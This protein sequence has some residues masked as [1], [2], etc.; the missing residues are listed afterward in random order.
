MDGMPIK[1]L[2]VGGASRGAL[3]FQSYVWIT[4]IG[5]RD[6]ADLKP[7]RQQISRRGEELAHDEPYVIRSGRHSEV[8]IHTAEH[9]REFLRKDSK[10]MSCV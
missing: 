10:G 3:V 2:N 6:Q 9:V 8:V 1:E 5:G 7:D 4:Q